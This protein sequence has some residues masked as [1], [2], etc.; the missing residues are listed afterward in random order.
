MLV[1]FPS[2]LWLHELLTLVKLISGGIARVSVALMIDRKQS[3]ERRAVHSF[4]NP[5]SSTYRP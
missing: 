1:P 4:P 5:L 2:A 3:C